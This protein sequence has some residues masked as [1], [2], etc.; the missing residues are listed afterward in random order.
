M[1]TDEKMRAEVEA[2][3]GRSRGDQAKPETGATDRD[4]EEHKRARTEKQQGC[5]REPGVKEC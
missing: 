3:R 1:E 2:A 5:E 4:P